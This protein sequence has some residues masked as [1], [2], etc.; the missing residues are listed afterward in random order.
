MNKMILK[1]IIREALC[2]D[3]PYG[4][5]TSMYIFNDNDKSNAV[6][7]AKQDGILAGVHIAKMVFKA[8]DRKIIFTVLKNDGDAIKKD[9]I[10]AKISGST[11]GMLG[12]ERTALNFMQRMSGIAT[13]SRRYQEKVSKYDIRIVDTRKTT[14]G[15][16][17][18][19][20]YSVKIGGAKNHRFSLSDAVMLKDNH[21]KA[22]G[23]IID[24]VKKIRL[25]I[26][27]TMKIEVETNSII[28]VKECIK[29]GADII[30][31]DNMS[32]EK[33]KEAVKLINKRAIVEASGN[34]TLDN[35]TEIAKT[36]IDII[37]V[38]ELTHSVKSL[39][40]SMKFE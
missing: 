20:K 26:P 36:G 4:D 32:I 15:L 7:I 5:M 35:I 10:I 33:M 23:S 6:L 11:K 24:S 28:Q 34:I 9:D 17:V 40:I 38:G 12:A 27:H 29:A 8:I 3:I 16:R 14:P 21:I 19:E 18:L 1:K 22:A 39:D 13:L 25:N 31:L 30:M 2:E 37:S